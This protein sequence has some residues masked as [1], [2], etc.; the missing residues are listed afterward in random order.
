MPSTTWP[1]MSGDASRRQQLVMQA[2]DRFG[3]GQH[4]VAVVGQDLPPAFVAEERL[5]GQFLELLDL[6]RDRGLRPSQLASGLGDAPGLDDRDE[7]P[8]HPDVDADQRHLTV[9]PARFNHGHRL[10]KPSSTH[11]TCHRR[12]PAQQSTRCTCRHAEKRMCLGRRGCIPLHSPLLSFRPSRSECSNS[13]SISVTSNQSRKR[14]DLTGR[15]HDQGERAVED[16][17]GAIAAF[18][19]ALLPGDEVFPSA[20]VGRRA[21]RPRRCACGKRSGPGPA[22]ALAAAFVSRGGLDAPRSARR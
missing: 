15:E 20:S 22:E 7:G 17:T 10:A 8:K 14:N 19:D 3:V 16:G 5:V 13:A 12:W 2:E 4:H 9:E 1:S 11:E 6:E 18:V 21:W